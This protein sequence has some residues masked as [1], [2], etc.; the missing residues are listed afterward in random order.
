MLL[1]VAAVLAFGGPGVAQEPILEEAK[2]REL[3]RL[4]R[5][6]GSFASGEATVYAGTLAATE[7]QLGRTGKTLPEGPVVAA[8]EE[9]VSLPGGGVGVR[10]TVVSAKHDLWLRLS[11]STDEAGITQVTRL[12]PLHGSPGITASCGGC[13]ADL[14]KRPETIRL[15]RVEALGRLRDIA[16][17]RFRIEL[18]GRLERV[19]PSGLKLDDLERLD[20]GL[21]AFLRG[22]VIAFERRGSEGVQ[23]VE[24][25]IRSRVAPPPHSTPET[26]CERVTR[27]A[28]ERFVDLN[29]LGR[30]GVRDV[31]VLGREICCLDHDAHGEAE[32]CSQEEG[33]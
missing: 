12:R 4:Q 15:D 9:R 1:A 27:Y 13:L 33:R 5:R 14:G 8:L 23:R 29:D 26:R 16:N 3:D 31:E 20:P 21:E 25:E 10:L 18:S 19:P 6:V 2:Q 28:A 24:G 17:T 32:Q 30:F 11:Q 7:S 22:E